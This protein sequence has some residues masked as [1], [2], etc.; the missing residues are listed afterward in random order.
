MA[1][2]GII[3]AGWAGCAAALEL[4]ERGHQVTLFEAARIP[5]G[6]A[7]TVPLHDQNLDNGQHIL[8]GAYSE[9][10]R[11]MRRVGVA[12]DEVFLRVPL[13]MH[14]PE[15]VDG[16]QFA[17]GRLP[18]PLHLA[19]GLL[20]AK[21]LHRDDRL[22]LARFTTTA[23]WMGWR[24]H[25]DCSVTT[26]LQRFDQT[27]RVIRLM[28]R[29]LCVAALNTEPDVA[30]AQVFLNV[31][32]DSFGARRA[33][34]DMLIPKASLSQ[35]FPEAAIARVVQRGGRYLSGVTIKALESDAAGWRVRAN[36]SD[37]AA[38]TAGPAMDSGSLVDVLL[39]GVIVATDPARA[40]TLLDGIASAKTLA[41][42]AAL[43]YEPITTCYL[44]YAATLGLPRP[45]FALAD[46]P[47]R[48]HWGQ[49]VFDRGQLAPQHAGLMAVVVSAST[50]AM[51][52]GHE[53][54][55]KNIAQQLAT[56]FPA[57]F[58]QPPRWARCVT[59]KHA[60]FRCTP[61]LI[62]PDC[63][64]GVEHVAIAGDYTAGDYPATLE[65]AV[66]S[67]L[68]AARHL[69]SQRD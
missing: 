45:F 18:A 48:G 56:S 30:S 41:P 66:R 60:T 16:M 29:P 28:W 65:S 59:E 31:L 4:A 21:G 47:E 33:A 8:L 35:L 13:Q 32:R 37:A 36:R 63:D 53:A 54:L 49:F 34:S 9:T 27:A 38:R 11:M 58:S 69:T 23:R 40:L 43:G 1:R 17:A 12:A 67:G 6:R 3:G 64:I 19:T 42:L 62:R 15:D 22:A 24:M 51:L 26:L 55:S 46:D 61:G 5:G 44:Q 25:E 68:A 20:R 57:L 50:H 7:R 52:D 10:L 39:D 14:Y 2:I